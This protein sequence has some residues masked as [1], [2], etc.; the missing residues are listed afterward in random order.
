MCKKLAQ[1]IRLLIQKGKQEEVQKRAE[2]ASE[3]AAVAG[4]DHLGERMFQTNGSFEV[5]PGIEDPVTVEINRNS[6]SDNQEKHL[7]K[8]EFLD[9]INK[10]K[11]TGSIYEV[12]ELGFLPKYC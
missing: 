8:L 11:E 10:N 6:K 1:E 5:F 3:Y 12:D 9:Q 7:P 2:A 4:S